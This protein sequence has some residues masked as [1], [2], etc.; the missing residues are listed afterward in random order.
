MI[1]LSIYLQ[2]RVEEGDGLYEE[3]Q[4]SNSDDDQGASL[5][6]VGESMEDPAPGE[7]SFSIL[8][9]ILIPFIVAGLG[10]VGAGIVLDIV[11]VNLF[12]SS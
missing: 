8:I 9:Q 10:M 4:S 1:S 3:Q 2:G 11:Q 6:Q 12:I 5:L 7:S